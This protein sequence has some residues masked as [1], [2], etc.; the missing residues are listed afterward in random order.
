MIKFS[1]ESGTLID[2]TMLIPTPI[3]ASTAITYTAA[4]TAKFGDYMELEIAEV[5]FSG[6]LSEFS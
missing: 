2:E 4:T 1:F 3:E 6:V 5:G